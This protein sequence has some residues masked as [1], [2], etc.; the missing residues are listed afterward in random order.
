MSSRANA[1]ALSIV[2]IVPSE[3]PVPIPSRT[4]LCLFEVGIANVIPSECEGPLNCS[5]LPSLGKAEATVRSLAL[6]IFGAR[7]NARQLWVT[8]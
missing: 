6:K 8:F 3:V 5:Y 1:R 7:D 4:A 2:L